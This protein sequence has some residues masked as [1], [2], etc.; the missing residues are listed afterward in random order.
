M[1]LYC[2]IIEWVF[3]VRR[4]VL[5]LYYDILEWVGRGF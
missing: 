4:E 3:S 1:F 5:L 2:A